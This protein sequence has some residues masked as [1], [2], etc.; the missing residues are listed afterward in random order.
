MLHLASTCLFCIMNERPTNKYDAAG[1][2]E[3]EV[4]KETANALDAVF[5]ARECLAFLVPEL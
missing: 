5:F 4:A 2:E 1:L 3:E